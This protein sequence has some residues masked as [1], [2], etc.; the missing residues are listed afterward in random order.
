MDSNTFQAV[1][2]KLIATPTD[3]VVCN[4]KGVL[5]DVDA[6]SNIV[7]SLKPRSAGLLF[8]TPQL[9]SLWR[10]L[11]VAPDKNPT[12]AE[13]ERGTLEKSFFNAYQRNDLNCCGTSV[14]PARS[15]SVKPKTRN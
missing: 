12:Q 3:G 4:D 7:S 13:L 14:E 10:R 8:S 15:A 11:N 9:Q 2:I 5:G 1:R 6:S